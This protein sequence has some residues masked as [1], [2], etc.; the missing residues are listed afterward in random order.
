M[1]RMWDLRT[2]KCLKA[3]TH[4]K[5]GIRAL[6]NHHQ[7]FTFASAAADKIRIWKQPEGDQLRTIDNP[8]NTVINAMAL[9]Q[10]NV[11]VTGGDDGVLKFFDWKSGHCF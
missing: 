1:V 5:K 2:A 10:D 9:N 4:H 7:E 11:L 6:V 3:L 8:D